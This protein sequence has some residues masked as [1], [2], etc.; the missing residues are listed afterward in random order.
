MDKV[1]LVDRRYSNS[2]ISFSL[3]PNNPRGLGIS[4]FFHPFLFLLIFQIQSIAK[5]IK[6]FS[7]SSSSFSGHIGI[8]HKL[9]FPFQPDIFFSS[10]TFLSQNQ[11]KQNNA[12]TFID[13]SFKKL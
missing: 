13:M 8:I 11:T 3:V 5:L 10:F 9:C 2:N 1:F 12:L 4:N 6:G 7:F